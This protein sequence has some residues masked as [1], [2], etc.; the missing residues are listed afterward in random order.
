MAMVGTN[1]LVHD[2]ALIV[3]QHV[4]MVVRDDALDLLLSPLFGLGHSQVNGLSLESLRLPVLRKI[5]HYPVANFWIASVQGSGLGGESRLSP[6]DPKTELEPTLV[7]IIRDG[8]ETVGKLLRVRV[9][10]AHAAKPTGINMKHLHP[11]ICGVAN[12]A[13]SNFLIDGHAATPAV[14]DCQGIVG[15]VPGFGI[16]ENRTNPAA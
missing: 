1:A 16:A 2:H 12:H 3:L 5:R 4:E 7:R 15:I 6:I 9:P 13:Q 11:E 8:R 10:V 14:I